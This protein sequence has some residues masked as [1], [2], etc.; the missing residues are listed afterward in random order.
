VAEAKAVVVE[1]ARA[2]EE[3]AARVVA[4]GRAPQAILLVAVGRTHQ[5][6]ARSSLSCG[7]YSALLVPNHAV[8]LTRTQPTGRISEGS[9]SGGWVRVA[10]FYR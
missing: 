2:A 8:E 9:V 3:E 6:E 7:H 4:D 10:H 1:G 5:Q